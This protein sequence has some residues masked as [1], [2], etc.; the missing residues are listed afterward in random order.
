MDVTRR[1]GLVEM[2]ST[3]SD[4]PVGLREKRVGPL[5]PGRYTVIA[6]AENGLKARRRVNLD[7]GDE[8]TVTLLLK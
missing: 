5:A 8:K 1:I 3:V 7:A 4:R 2:R 6:T